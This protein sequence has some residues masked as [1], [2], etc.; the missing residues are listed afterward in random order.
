VKRNTFVTFYAWLVSL[1]SLSFRFLSFH[2]NFLL[3]STRQTGKPTPM[4]DGSNDAFPPKEVPF[5]ISLKKIGV[6]G[7]GNP[8]NRQKVGVVHGFPVKLGESIKSHIS[9]KPRDIDTKFQMQVETEKYTLDF[10]S[11]VTYHQI[12]LAAAA[13]L[14][15]FKL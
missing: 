14:K 3:T 7:V 1:S 2:I 10:G 4:V 12:K 15:K 13:I 9:V 5:G 11:K 8:K 6:Y